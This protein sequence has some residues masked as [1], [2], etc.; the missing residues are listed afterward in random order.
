[1]PGGI[2]L[3]SKALKI[4]DA[5]L[6]KQVESGKLLAKDVLPLVAK[7]MQ[8]VAN[9]A[10]ALDKKL[11]TTRVQQGRFNKELETTMDLIFTS[12]FDEG[13][14]NMFKGFA[15]GLQDSTS[16]MKGLGQ[17]FKLFFNIVKSVGNIVIP[18][19]D[20]IA[21]SLGKV[22]EGFNFLFDTKQGNIILGMATMAG[23][24][25]AI[26]KG[27]SIMTAALTKFGIVSGIVSKIWNSIFFKIAAVVLLADEFAALFDD[28]R[29]GQLEVMAGKQLSYGSVY[30]EVFDRT[31]LGLGWKGLNSITDYFRDPTPPQQTAP[32]IINNNIIEGVTSSVDSQMSVYN[33]NA[34]IQGR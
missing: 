31:P 6:L 20:S 13:A 26:A 11:L 4:S 10:G 15:E 7:E 23:G 5:E 14:A 25:V 8:R 12:G 1:M 29:T 27:F 18:I 34:L 22:A 30:K 3:F 16:G 32:T 28:E 2:Q 9:T 19:F 17:I 33:N 24:A 21:F